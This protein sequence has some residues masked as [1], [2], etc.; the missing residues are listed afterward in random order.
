MERIL[1]V[2][3]DPE[4][5]ELLRRTLQD[6]GFEVLE[7]ADGQRALDAHAVEA[8]DLIVLD[9]TLPAVDGL[10]V[11]SR[12]RS[13][14]DLPV[15]LLT[16]HGDEADRVRGLEMGADDYVV[17][18]FSP[19]ELEARIRSVLRRTGTA[20]RSAPPLEFGDL[21]IDPSAREVV[22]DNELVFTTAKEFDLLLFMA[23]APRQVFTRE[24][25]LRQV[26]D[27]S[28]RWQ[29]PGTVTEQVRRLRQKIE[30]VEGPPRYL[31]TVRGVGYVF[32]LR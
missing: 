28:G 3:D 18:P 29:D 19:R 23:S 24:Q 6:N 2:D 22:V 9:L 16:G 25:L 32:E 7:A 30:P 1:V 8:V 27:S 15:I 4:V 26:W 17:K 10:E 14:S 11:L 31:H 13:K 5:R 20:D 21:R 12:V